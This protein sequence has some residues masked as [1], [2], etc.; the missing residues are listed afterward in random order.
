[1][2]F[3]VQC[4]NDFVKVNI[5]KD[6][7]VHNEGIG[8]CDGNVF[9]GRT[10]LFESWAKEEWPNIVI[11]EFSINLNGFSWEYVFGFLERL[12]NYL[13]YKWTKKGLKMPAVVILLT[14]KLPKL[15]DAMNLVE[16]RSKE[17]REQHL[18]DIFESLVRKSS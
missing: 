13:L 14:H 18:K 15:L 10:F 17:K 11:E 5:S 12:N 1:M 16:M 9:L 7:F 8:G 6:S 2:G 3:Y 4:L